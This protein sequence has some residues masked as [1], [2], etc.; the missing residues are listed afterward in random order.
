MIKDIK[1]YEKYYYVDTNGNI[2]SK[3]RTITIK[4]PNPRVNKT[5]SY[6]KKGRKLTPH[7]KK[8]GYCTVHL[9][10]ENHIIKEK[11]IHRIV[12]EAFIKNL[13]NY[14]EVNH[15]DE[16][17]Q[18][19]CVDNL[20]WCNRLYNYTYGTASTKRINNQKTKKVMQFDKTNQYLNTYNSINEAERVTGIK[21]YNI[22]A[23]CKSN[24]KTAGGYVWKY[25]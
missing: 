11:L 13:N 7:L 12:A 16:N 18:N 1:D 5:M 23:V 25:V 20:E 19:N 10:D 24:R 22:S 17:K 3:D 21:H 6:I 14:K 9:S 4:N 2:Y 8:N 15:K